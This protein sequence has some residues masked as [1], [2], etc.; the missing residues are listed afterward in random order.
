MLG[1]VKRVCPEYDEK[2]GYELG[3][4]VWL[5]GW[6]DV[7]NGDV[8]PIPAKGDPTPR[9]ANYSL[10][11]ADL[12]RDVRKDLAAPKLPFVIGV[13]GVDGARPNADVAAFRAAMAAPAGLPEFAG[14]V[15]AVQTAPY[16]D[17]PLGAID[18]KRERVR[19]MGYEL[20]N[21]SKGKP[22]AD[23]SMTEQQQ[24]DYMAAYERKLISPEEAATWKRGASN[25]GYHYL[26]CA[27]TFALMGRAFA[28]A[29]LKL[30][31]ADPARPPR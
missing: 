10:W 6:N 24:R 23:G 1:D 14:N 12:I 18:V 5:Q 15:A 9:Y 11:L 2:A 31:G 27:K 3:G 22:N 28:E 29:T 20:K 30:A 19:Q 17:E 4:F 25:A 8:Y 7:V 16:W 13:M 26:G 21:K